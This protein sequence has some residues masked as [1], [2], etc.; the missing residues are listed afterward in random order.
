ML[1][2]NKTISNFDF[3]ELLKEEDLAE[4]VWISG[5]N[6]MIKLKEKDEEGND[7]IYNLSEWQDKNRIEAR[8]YINSKNE[9]KFL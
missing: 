7:V 6:I 8:L 2:A 9:V 1:N 3:I 5:S 4:K